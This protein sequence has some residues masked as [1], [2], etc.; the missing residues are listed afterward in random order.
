MFFNRI[1][2][3]EIH[4]PRGSWP[5]SGRVIEVRDAEDADIVF[6][7]KGIANHVNVPEITG[8]VTV[9]LI[10]MTPMDVHA[11]RC[12]NRREY[13][14]YGIIMMVSIKNALGKNELNLVENE[15]VVTVFKR[16]T[17]TIGV[18]QV[19]GMAARRIRNKLGVGDTVRKGGACMGVFS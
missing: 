19:A 5:A 11:Q 17:D 14:S 7:K 16:D 8:P 10:E 18:V 12:T 15:K 9:V 4:R 1:D 3:N 13:Y 2:Q 6:E